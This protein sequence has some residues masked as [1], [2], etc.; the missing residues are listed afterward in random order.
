MCAV[1]KASVQ[2]L[3]GG[4][5]RSCGDTVIIKYSTMRTILAWRGCVRTHRTPGY[6]PEFP[7]LL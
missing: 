6:V 1:V 2:L 3:V 4:D 5:N 7:C